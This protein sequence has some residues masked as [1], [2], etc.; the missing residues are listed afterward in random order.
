M[1]ERDIAQWRATEPAKRIAV[2]VRT[3]A[4][5]RE[6]TDRL[7][8]IA[9]LEPGKI[10]AEALG[11]VAYVAALLDCTRPRRL[12]P[13]DGPRPSVA[14]ADQSRRRNGWRCGGP[15]GRALAARR[16]IWL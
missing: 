1:A 14:L 9:T 3:A 2:L 12:C 6:R 7:A 13:L 5:L 8:R 10:I 15:G 11:E 16:L 4:L